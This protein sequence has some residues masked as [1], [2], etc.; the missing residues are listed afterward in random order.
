[1]KNRQAVLQ[2]GTE[3]PGE[4]EQASE[5]ITMPTT[6]ASAV[7]CTFYVLYEEITNFVQIKEAKPMACSAASHAHRLILTTAHLLYVGVSHDGG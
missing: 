2:G 1:M 4:G 7:V 5:L 3:Q 6:S